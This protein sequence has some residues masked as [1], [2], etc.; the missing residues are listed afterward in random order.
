LEKPATTDR[1]QAKVTTALVPAVK[2]IVD[3][4]VKL[5]QNAQLDSMVKFVNMEA[6]QLVQ[7]HSQTVAV[8]V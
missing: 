7:D 5:L 6:C 4:S 8:P 1:S 2:D 3:N